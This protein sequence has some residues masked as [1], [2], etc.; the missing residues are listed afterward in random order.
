[1]VHTHTHTQKIQFQA[2]VQTALLLWLVHVAVKITL[3]SLAAP[4]EGYSTA[5]QGPG[6]PS[7]LQQRTT[8]APEMLL[9]PPRD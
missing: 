9:S 2:S 6:E 1:M 3:E 7:F 8:Q 4:A 5:L